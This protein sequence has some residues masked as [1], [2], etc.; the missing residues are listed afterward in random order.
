MTTWLHFVGRQYYQPRTF[1]AEAK[2]YGVT[3]RVAL[4]V[5]K[6]MHYGDEVYLATYNNHA[7]IFGLFCIQTISGLSK[8]AV[9]KIHEKYQCTQVSGGGRVVQR[10]CGSYIEGPT[11]NVDASLR[12]IAETLESVEN[13]GLL[14]VGGKFYPHP[15]VRLRDIPFMQGFRQFDNEKFTTALEEWKEVFGH[16][17]TKKI[18][19]L[20]GLFYVNK[21]SQEEEEEQ[22][23]GRV[24]EVQDYHRKTDLKEANA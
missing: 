14:M 7:E 22:W 2:K 1:I 4:K 15:R 12:E 11:Y 10:G 8:E 9:A 18:P 24:Q 23:W 21:D 17:P 5:L 6:K 13:P 20:K 16:L 19:L 3:R